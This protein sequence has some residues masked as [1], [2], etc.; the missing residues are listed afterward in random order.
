MAPRSTKNPIDK[1]LENVSSFE[2]IV[3][4]I[5]ENAASNPNF[6][7]EIIEIKKKNDEE[8]SN[9]QKLTEDGQDIVKLLETYPGLSKYVLSHVKGKISEYKSLGLLESMKG[10]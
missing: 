5:F 8:N 10:V 6:I 2:G 7:K 9:K 3:Q 1:L 4:S